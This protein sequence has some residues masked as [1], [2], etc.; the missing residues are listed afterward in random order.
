RE[1]RKH[2]YK[3]ISI[4]EDYRSLPDTDVL[5]ISEDTKSILITE[6][7]DFGEWVFAHKAKANGVILLRYDAKDL[8]KITK[9]L[10][11]ILSS[12]TT[13]LYGKFVVITPKKIRIREIV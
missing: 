6:D 12:H 3:I 11:K 8:T 9:S 5:K 1:L 13:S 10:I 2:S 7:K 4:L